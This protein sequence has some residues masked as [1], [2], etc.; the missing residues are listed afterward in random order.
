MEKLT[1]TLVPFADDPT[2]LV[3]I[4]MGPSANYEL[5]GRLPSGTQV[6]VLGRT[7]AGDWI[8]IE[9]PQGSGQ[10]AWVYYTLIQLDYGSLPVV[11]HPT[12]TPR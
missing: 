1:G 11:I 6:V 9:Y 10:T 2:G 5:A 4:R 8:E 7:E 3:N 12:P